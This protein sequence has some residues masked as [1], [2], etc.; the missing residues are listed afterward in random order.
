MLGALGV[1]PSSG[2][3]WFDPHPTVDTKRRA[4]KSNCAETT[5]PSCADFNGGRE[6]LVIVEKRLTPRAD[7]PAASL[8]CARLRESLAP[9]CSTCSGSRGQAS[10][11]LLRIVH[12]LQLCYRA[13]AWPRGHP[14]IGITPCPSGLASFFCVSQ[15]QLAQSYF[16]G[17]RTLSKSLGPIIPTIR[18]STAKHPSSGT[19]SRPITVNLL[20]AFPCTPAS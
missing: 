14:R 13:R 9:K 16:R 6:R 18:V 7:G 20:G 19:S 4:R 12:A 2:D 17:S 5:L 15:I 10:M 11:R 3:D 1:E 8:A